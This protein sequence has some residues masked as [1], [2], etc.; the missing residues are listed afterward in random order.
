MGCETSGPVKKIEPDAQEAQPNGAHVASPTSQDQAGKPDDGKVKPAQPLHPHQ[1]AEKREKPPSRPMS[2][3]EELITLARRTWNM[4]EKD[5]PLAA[6]MFYKRLFE[7]EPAVEVLFESVDMKLQGEMLMIMI[8]KAVECMDQPMKLIPMLKA[9]GRRHL[10]YGVNSDHYKT[11]GAALLWTL[12]TALGEK[13]DRETKAAW[14]WVYGVIAQTMQQG[15]AEH[16]DEMLREKEKRE[17]KE[18]EVARDKAEA[19]E[20]NKTPKTKAKERVSKSAKIPPD[21]SSSPTPTP[22]SNGNGNATTVSNSVASS[23]AGE[24]RSPTTGSSRQTPGAQHQPQSAAPAACP[25]PMV[26]KT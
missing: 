2:R 9:T 12:E 11:V 4:V 17:A 24:Q 25:F 7:I 10:K 20:N 3:E 16:E 19:R 8:G 15:A 5:A 21:S 18:K 22:N 13:W 26:V 14:S 23:D 1:P 6:S